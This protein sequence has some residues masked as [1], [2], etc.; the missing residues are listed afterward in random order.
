MIFQKKGKE[1]CLIQNC[2]SVTPS[3]TFNVPRNG[4]V[5][6]LKNCE[7]PG[8]CRSYHPEDARLLGPPEE[9]KHWTKEA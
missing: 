2:N 7:R 9:S 4:H 6:T 1:K 3:L 5:E 8:L